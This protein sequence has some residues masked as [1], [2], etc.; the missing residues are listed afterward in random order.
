MDWCLGIEAR[1][2]FIMPFRTFKITL[3][4]KRATEIIMPFRVIRVALERDLKLL[5]GFVDLAFCGKKNA[6][7]V[8]HDSRSRSYPRSELKLRERL[9][10]V[11]EAGENAGVLSEDFTVARVAP[12]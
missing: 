2:F 5:N 1:G 4:V 7:V 9:V 8:M 11:A 10:F 12:G 3:H 6:V